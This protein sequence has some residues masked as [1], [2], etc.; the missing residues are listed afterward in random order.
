M[1][2]RD[3]PLRFARHAE[4]IKRED[5]D[6]ADRGI[7]GAGTAPTEL[8]HEQCAQRPAHRAGE[9]AKQRQMRD[10]TTRMLAIQAAKSGKGRIIEP[11]PH[12]EANH[13]PSGDEDRQIWRDGLHQQTDRQQDGAGSQDR[14][15]AEALD[16][17][18][19]TR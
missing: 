10:R 18:T 14:A 4:Q 16:E 17:M 12:G 19:D 11:G 6:D 8:L 9:T 13:Q 1:P 15:T 5:H 7:G 2:V 3:R